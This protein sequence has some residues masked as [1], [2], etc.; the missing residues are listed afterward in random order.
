M[1]DDMRS[2]VEPGRLNSEPLSEGEGESSLESSLRC[3]LEG[4]FGIEAS[5]KRNE[6][7]VLLSEEQALDDLRVASL[8]RVRSQYDLRRKAVENAMI[9]AI[10]GYMG[11]CATSALETERKRAGLIFSLQREKR[12]EAFRR[13]G[14]SELLLKRIGQ[15]ID[16]AAAKIATDSPERFSSCYKAAAIQ[17]AERA[18]KAC[19]V[20]V[21]A[22]QESEEGGRSPV[23]S[24]AAGDAS[25][26]GA[27]VRAEALG[28]VDGL[29]A[30]TLGEHMEDAEDTL[31]RE[32]ERSKLVNELE[33]LEEKAN[34]AVDA[35]ERDAARRAQG[36]RM[37]IFEVPAFGD[38]EC[39]RVLAVDGLEALLAEVRTSYATYAR[40][41]RQGGVFC[42]FGLDFGNTIEADDVPDAFRVCDR[43]EAP[44]D[45]EPSAGSRAHAKQSLK[46]TDA[47]VAC[48]IERMREFNG[49]PFRGVLDDDPAEFAERFWY[50]LKGL[51]LFADCAVSLDARSWDSFIEQVKLSACEAG[52]SLACQMS[53]SQVEDFACA[54]ESLG[55]DSDRKG[56]ADGRD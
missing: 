29:F 25:A 21:A 11:E 6:A 54:L 5:A 43:E 26:L 51:L 8:R 36:Q 20:D 41:V 47:D 49:R 40:C 31:R 15:T 22:A 39:E 13:M 23:F 19:E 10:C 50:G 55:E 52:V 9:G 3:A 33:I 35:I 42:A 18:V 28:A 34:A 12:Y 45:E 32:G 24:S 38:V 37:P 48:V 46:P 53:A 27:D 17:F 16:A 14:S 7:R 1:V 2:G 4:V 30:D 56:D 44:E